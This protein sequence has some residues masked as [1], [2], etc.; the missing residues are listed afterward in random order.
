MFRTYLV[1]CGNKKRV[2]NSVVIKGLSEKTV[3]KAVE[4]FTGWKVLRV[5]AL[6]G[7]VD[8]VLEGNF[9]DVFYNEKDLMDIGVPEKQAARCA[10]FQPVWAFAFHDILEYALYVLIISAIVIGAAWYALGAKVWYAGNPQYDKL[11]AEATRKEAENEKAAD[12]S[13]GGIIRR[14]RTGR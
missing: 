8:S 3:C 4:Y 7:Y 13:I 10:N 6:H 12:D 1:I 5:E 9:E 11:V 2:T 14:A